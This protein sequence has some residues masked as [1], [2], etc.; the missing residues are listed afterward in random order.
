MYPDGYFS[1]KGGPKD[2]GIDRHHEG[3]MVGSL[4][5]GSTGRNIPEMAWRGLG[6]RGLGFHPI[7]NPKP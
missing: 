2:P 5:K 1:R 4:L 7:L 6:F 3:I